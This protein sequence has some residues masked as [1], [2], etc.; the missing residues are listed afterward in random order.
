MNERPYGVRRTA[1]DVDD[2]DGIQERVP[3]KDVAMRE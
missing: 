3:C 2:R 1:K